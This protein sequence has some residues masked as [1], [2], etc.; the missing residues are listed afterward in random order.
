[1]PPWELAYNRLA[2]HDWLR[3][4]HA[5]RGPLTMTEPENHPRWAE[6]AAQ[7]LGVHWLLKALCTTGA[8]TAFMV[9][10]FTLLRHPLFPVTLIP[11]TAFDR[12]V[13]FEPWSLLPY[14]SLWFYISLVPALLLRRELP[15]YLS[16]VTLLAILG[17]SIFFFWPT[18]VPAPDIDWHRYPSVAFLKTVDA[19]GN[20]CPSLHVA[21]ALLTAL[22]L[23]HLLRRMGAP[24][25]TLAVNWIWCAAITYSTL[26]IKQHLALDALAGALLGLAVTG[27]LLGLDR[28][29]GK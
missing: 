11:V 15:L 18:A 20:A 24:L 3:L 19:S 8:I 23:H 16:S 21:Y 7:R 26:A 9:G 29:A 28:S 13:A 14:A 4:V 27:P 12:W 10:Y 5:L 1:M 25:A 2:W 6:Q 22:W 17:F